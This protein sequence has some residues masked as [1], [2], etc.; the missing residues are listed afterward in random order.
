MKRKLPLLYV[1]QNENLI[2]AKD[3]SPEKGDMM[4]NI[5]VAVGERKEEGGR[6]ESAVG[7]RNTHQA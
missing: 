2:E 3:S 5:D 1:L 6:I 7:L 4:E